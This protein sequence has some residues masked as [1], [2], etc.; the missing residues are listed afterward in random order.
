MSSLIEEPN[1]GMEKGWKGWVGSKDGKSGR[2]GQR[3]ELKNRFTCTE[4]EIGYILY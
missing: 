2:K 4:T 3:G 1:L